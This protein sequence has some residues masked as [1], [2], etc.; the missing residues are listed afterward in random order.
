MQP[1]G[2]S[3]AGGFFFFIWLLSVIAIIIGY[4]VFLVAIWR[5]M[6][7]HEAIAETLKEIAGHLK[8]QP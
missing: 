3:F 4:V 6:K 2:P 8:S 7:A 1:I 5:G